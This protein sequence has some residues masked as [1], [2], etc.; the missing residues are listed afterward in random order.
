MESNRL[1]KTSL[2][3]MRRRA[4]LKGVLATG[5]A[6][7]AAPHWLKA[8]GI[9][10]ASA[11]DVSLPIGMNSFSIRALRWNDLQVLDYAASLKLDA[12]FLQDSMD[13]GS[14]DPAHWTEVRNRAEQLGLKLETGGSAVFPKTPDA[15]QESVDNI[16]KNAQRAKGMGSPSVRFL[17][18]SDRSKLPSGSMEQHIETMIKL[19]RTV[20][21]Q[22]IDMGLKVALEVHKDFLTSEFK[23]IV[24]GA[25][26]DVVGIYLD[27]GNPVFVQEHPMTTVETL[28]P[29]A[30]CVHLR[31]SVVYEQPEG[32][33]VQWVPLGEGMIDFHEVIAKVAKLC[34]N[35]DVNI[36][37]KP[38]TGRKPT[39]LPLYHQD[40]W[41]AY[42]DARAGD[43]ARFL[44]LAK[45]GKPY[46]K[47]MLTDDTPSK[48]T[49]QN[50]LF[51]AQEKEHLERSIKYAKTE[52]ALGR[53][54]KK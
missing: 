30:V 38:I 12:V 10:R 14:M 4:F 9:A 53:R 51:G 32:V 13:S 29:Y 18:A 44:A 39:I 43:L 17:G 16:L 7:M 22:L 3:Q 20:R 26:K 6:S 1:Q 25:G 45:T 54:W 40:Y 19:F 50:L 23:Q 37:I 21:P 15:F 34:P 11:S 52:L 31:D 35:P 2:A 28:A 49:E 42:P 47:P 33:A 8:D 5:A 48:P 41:K 27:T 46:D 36:Y 24:E